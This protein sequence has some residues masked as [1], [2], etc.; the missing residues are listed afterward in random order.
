MA[1]LAEVLEGLPSDYRDVI[2]RRE[3][4]EQSFAQIGRMTG[5]SEEA[6]RKLHTRALLRVGESLKRG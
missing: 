1:H 4:N 2:E 3:F 5:R 6:A